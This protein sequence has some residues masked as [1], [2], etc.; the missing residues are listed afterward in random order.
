MTSNKLTFTNVGLPDSG[1]F[2]CVAENKHD[3]IVSSTRVYVLGN[4]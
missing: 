3:M 1:M 2:Q 4:Y